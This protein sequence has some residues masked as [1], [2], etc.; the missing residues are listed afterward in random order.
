M[1]MVGNGWWMGMG[2]GGQTPDAE[3]QDKNRS[4]ACQVIRMGVRPLKRNVKART[5]TLCVR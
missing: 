3:R 2:D 1:E 4:A 5:A